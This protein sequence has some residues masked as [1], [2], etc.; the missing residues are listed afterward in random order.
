MPPVVLEKCLVSL[1][2]CPRIALGNKGTQSYPLG[3]GGSRR[4]RLHFDLHLPETTHLSKV[5]LVSVP[6]IG[7]D[8]FRRSPVSQ[9]DTRLRWRFRHLLASPLL[10]KSHQ[11]I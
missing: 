10:T 2:N 4:S 6:C 3:P 1:K 11:V 7:C 5:R 9:E 8:V